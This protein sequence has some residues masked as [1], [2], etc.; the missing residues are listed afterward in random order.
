MTNESSLEKKFTKLNNIIG[1]CVFIIAATVY[2]KTVEPT[3]SFWDC[4]ENLSIYYKLEI[5]HPPGEPFLQLLQHCVSLLSFGNVHNVAPIVNRACATYCA[6]CILFLFWITTFFAKKLY[7][8][9]GE[10]TEGR[11]YA[12]LGAGFIAATSFTFADS[13]WFSATEASVW[14]MSACFTSLMF[15]CSTKYARATEHSERW[16]ILL[17]F[18]VGLAIGVHFLCLL[19]IPAAVLLFFLKN[20][21]DGLRAKWLTGLLSKITKNKN[22]QVGIA[23]FIAGALILGGVKSIVIPGV[24]GVASWFELFFVNSF[25]L[26]FNSAPRGT[27]YMGA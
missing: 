1:W 17:S 25:G 2:W 23:G 6:L 21:P 19:F 12:I 15:W 7:T 4:G 14:A 16:L 9:H 8:R 13:L 11:M 5:G 27:H 24:I 22:K 3:V 18:L 10:L 20:Y 26:P